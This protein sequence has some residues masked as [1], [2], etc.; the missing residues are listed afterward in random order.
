MHR[1]SLSLSEIKFNFIRTLAKT[2]EFLSLMAY[3][4]RGL[5]T[6]SLFFFD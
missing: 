2:L 5:F 6:F 3:I 1:N 4:E